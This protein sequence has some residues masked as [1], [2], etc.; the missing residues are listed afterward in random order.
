VLLG[1]CV[2]S[3]VISQRAL[4]KHGGSQLLGLIHGWQYEAIQQFNQYF[5][6]ADSG[7]AATAH[8]ALPPVLVSASNRGLPRLAT[9]TCSR[10]LQRRI[11]V[12]SDVPYLTY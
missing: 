11:Y 9:F 4:V 5:S 3:S 8:H 6:Q 10:I 7:T 12:G 1:I 2:I